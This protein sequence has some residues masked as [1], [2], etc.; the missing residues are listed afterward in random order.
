VWIGREPLEHGS[1][2][3]GQQVAEV[4]RRVVLDDLRRGG[5]RRRL[6]AVASAPAGRRSP[7]TT[8][9]EAAWTDA[10]VESGLP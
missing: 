6:E 4:L 8:L 5:P 1:L 10:G 9:V 2:R 3:G 7:E